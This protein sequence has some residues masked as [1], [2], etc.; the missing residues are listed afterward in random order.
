M[1][2]LWHLRKY[3][4]KERM[5][6][7]CSC[8][9]SKRNEFRWIRIPSTGIPVNRLPRNHFLTTVHPCLSHTD[10][11]R[12]QFPMPARYAIICIP[13]ATIDEVAVPSMNAVSSSKPVQYTAREIILIT[14]QSTLGCAPNVGG[15]QLLVET[16]GVAET[17]QALCV[18]IGA[19]D[20]SID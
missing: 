20:G 6:P 18:S 19:R 7:C 11:T 10:L 14:A 17:S 1:I 4:H 3:T 15:L 9:L 12:P 8:M 16:S 5:H 2:S 13:S